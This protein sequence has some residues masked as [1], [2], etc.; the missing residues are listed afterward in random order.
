M[1]MGVS[2]G[3][4]VPFIV[5]DEKLDGSVTVGWPQQKV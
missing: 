3:K 1:E 5:S 4:H 2:L